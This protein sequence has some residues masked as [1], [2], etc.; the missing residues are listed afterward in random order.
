M[1][2]PA[3]TTEKSEK[4]PFTPYQR[5]LF[6]FLSV[7][8]FFEGYDFLAL[9]Q[10][11]PNVRADFGLSI[12]WA[13]TIVFCINV[14]TVIAYLL[15]RRADSWGRR[16]V[17][18]WTI[19]GYTVTTFLT[20]FSP[21]VAVFVVLQLLA[22]IFLIAEW[23]I[24][25]VI[26]AEEFPASRRG[27]VIGVIQA[28]SSLGSVFCAGVAPLL[29]STD[30]GWRA[31]YF[32]GVL[33][34]AILGYARRGLRETGRFLAQETISRRPLVHIWRTPYRARMLKLAAVW[35]FAYI[36]AQNSVAFWKEFAVGEREFSDAD[37]G[38]AISVAAVVAMPL[39]F[40]SGKL[41]DVVGRRAGAAIVFGI[42]SVATFACY[43]LKGFVPL[44]VALSL[45]IFAASAYLPILNAYGAELFP[46]DL[47]GDAFAWSN[48]LLGRI[49]YVLSPLAVGAAAEYWGAFGPVVAATSIFPI[50]ALALVWRWFPETK[51]EELERTS[52][53]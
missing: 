40:A 5:R 19:A 33:P 37:V 26:A 25:M 11:L 41:I 3:A 35:F 13:G 6:V 53:L 1:T 32:V 21:N 44:T 38:L 4:V 15:V 43:T 12:G 31:V 42:A 9:T 23:A 49:S 27:M 24:S 18:T 10:I 20:G 16:P 39:L 7:A 2:D 50:V 14:G 29:L 45:G 34:L 46:T 47:R 17:L 48:N 8:T 36:C 51:L 52:I 30:Y 28:T 22:R